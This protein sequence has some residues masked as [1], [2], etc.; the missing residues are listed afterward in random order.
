MPT[1]NRKD[2]CNAYSYFI[3]RW[4]WGFLNEAIAPGD[5]RIREAALLYSRKLGRIQARGLNEGG[6]FFPGLSGKT[7]PPLS[8]NAKTIYVA[9]VKKHIGVHSTKPACKGCS[10]RGWVVSKKC[11]LLESGAAACHCQCTGKG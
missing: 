5:R 6:H 3:D 8:R 10:G 11:P 7:P 9:L 1:F 4:R 2:I